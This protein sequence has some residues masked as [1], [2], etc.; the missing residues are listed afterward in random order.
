MRNWRRY[1]MQ[2]SFEQ[3]HQ[4]EGSA[5]WAPL[6]AIRCRMNCSDRFSIASRELIGVC[7]PIDLFASCR[8]KQ[9]TADVTS[10]GYSRSPQGR[11]S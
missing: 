5:K 1:E 11:R 2:R 3:F 7:I 8:H 9:R 10:I 6:K 4:I